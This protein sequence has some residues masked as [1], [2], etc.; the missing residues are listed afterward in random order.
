MTGLGPT[1]SATSNPSAA[2]RPRSPVPRHAAGGDL[3]EPAATGG[4][5]R[6]HFRLAGVTGTGGERGRGRR[7]RVLGRARDRRRPPAGAAVGRRATTDPPPTARP[8]PSTGPSRCRRRRWN[9][10]WEGFRAVK[11]R[12]GRPAPA[13]DVAAVRAVRSAL[14]DDVAS[15]GHFNQALVVRCGRSGVPPPRRRG[16]GVDRGAYRHDDYAGAASPRAQLR[17]PLQIGEN[18]AG[19]HPM[20]AAL[21]H[22]ASDFVMP[23]LDR[24]GGVTGWTRAATLAEA[25]GVPM[26]SHLYPEVGMTDGEVMGCTPAGRAVAGDGGRDRR[27]RAARERGCPGTRTPSPT[28]ASTES[29]ARTRTSNSGS[30]GLRFADAWAWDVPERRTA[31]QGVCSGRRGGGG[32]G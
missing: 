27:V 13:D 4:L 9:W 29:R 24:I 31:G 7:R 32:A 26:S 6:G 8:G 3:A 14:P 2:R 16:P 19:I 5:L 20:V 15:D 1:C 30:P 21:A 17:T 25:S 12:L 28:T 18:F 22:G 23:D 10:W 11:I